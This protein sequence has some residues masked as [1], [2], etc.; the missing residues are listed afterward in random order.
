MLEYKKQGDNIIDEKV[1]RNDINVIAAIKGKPLHT[2]VDTL[3]NLSNLTSD[4][5]SNLT[6]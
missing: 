1:V 4:E 2:I 6:G 3:I 5:V